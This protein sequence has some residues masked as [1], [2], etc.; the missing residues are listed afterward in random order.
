MEAKLS[1]TRERNSMLEAELAGA[2]AE[3]AKNVDE[4]QAKPSVNI[5]YSKMTMVM[6][7]D[8]IEVAQR[9]LQELVGKNAYSISRSIVAEF[10]K[11]YAGSW[12]ALVSGSPGLSFASTPRH[13]INFNIGQFNIELFNSH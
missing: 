4:L 13:Y 5:H 3:V 7:Q 12:Q 2:E 1:E 6:E 9:A 11:R 10:D 8:A